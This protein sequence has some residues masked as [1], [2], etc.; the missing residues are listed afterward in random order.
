MLKLTLPYGC[1]ASDNLRKGLA[2]EAWRKYKTAREAATMIAMSQIQGSRPRYKE[3][4]TVELLFWLPD[5]RRRDPSNLLKG[6]LDALTG[7]AYDDDSRI[8]SLSWLVMGLDR[9]NP[10][11]EITVMPG[12]YRPTWPEDV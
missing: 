6:C 2:K 3:P 8:R 5:E 10:R 9:D 12:V 4:V 1:L 11:V 7:L